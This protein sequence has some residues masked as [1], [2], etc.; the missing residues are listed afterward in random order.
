MEDMHGSSYY[1]AEHLTS[2]REKLSVHSPR[3]LISNLELVDYPRPLP[4]MDRHQFI[5]I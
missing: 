2:I 5:I 3:R 1:F 4:P